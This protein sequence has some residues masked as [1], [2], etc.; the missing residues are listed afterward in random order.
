ML[1]ID[2]T[3]LDP[4]AH[5]VT[6]EPKAGAVDL[7]PETFRDIHVDALLHVQRE[8]IL[9]AFEAHATAQLLCDRT[10]RAFDQPV[11]G[12]YAVL[13]A[14][15]G[16]PKR[17]HGDEEE[18][19]ELLPSDRTIDVTDVVRDT[20]LLAVPRRKVAPGAEDE[21]IETR[22]GEAEGKEQIDPRWEALRALRSDAPDS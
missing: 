5:H 14:P 18:V 19:R 3:A 22:F 17:E 10:L 21:E 4:G 7:D 6:L 1:H 16:T 11:D 2:I 12:T 20:L 9:V 13:F 15:P 8:R